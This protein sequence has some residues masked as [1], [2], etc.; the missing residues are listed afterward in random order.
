L[1]SQHLNILG[2]IDLNKAFGN[3]YIII[4]RFDVGCSAFGQLDV[5][6]IVISRFDAGCYVVGTFYITVH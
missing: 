2:F 5:D 4:R 6:C 3:Y 1:K